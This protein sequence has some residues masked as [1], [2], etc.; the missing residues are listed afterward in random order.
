VIAGDI[1]RLRVEQFG[2]PE[3]GIAFQKETLDRSR[4]GVLVGCRRIFFLDFLVDGFLA[5]SRGFSGLPR[6]DSV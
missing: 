1:Q 5:F 4:A 3:A 2:N 6:V